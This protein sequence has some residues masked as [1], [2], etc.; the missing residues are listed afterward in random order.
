MLAFVLRW[1]ARLSSS[2]AGVVLVY[3]RVGGAGSGDQN[4]EILPTVGRRVFDRQLRDVRRHYCV[5][6]AAEILAAVRA[7]RR[8]RRFPVAITF[9]DDLPEHVREAL[10][11][12][13][14]AGLT[15]T[16]FLNGASLEGPHSFWW[17]DL[18]RAV[19]A[20]LVTPGDVPHVDAGPALARTPRAILDLSGAITRLAPEQRSEVATAL[21]DAVGPPRAEDGLR[22]QDARTLVEGGCSV[23]FHTLRHE[24]L[25][26]LS[27]SELAQAL[28]DGREALEAAAGTPIDAIAYPYGK[29][30]D[31]VAAAARAAG[32]AHGF[33]TLRGVV[34]LDTDPLLIPR[35]VP[36]LS[37]SG[38]R[39]RLARLVSAA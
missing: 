39:L 23:G 21:R 11:A 26:A 29:G 1:R 8:G 24:V 33:T 17:Q 35:T 3:H 36:D 9:D 22:A 20:E 25:P 37:A 5:V 14:T 6:P 4:A 10:P 38:L 18:Q 28:R 31:R 15:A 19:D 12:L 16:F 30:D 34:S 7:R 2:R 13:R 32:F 27:D